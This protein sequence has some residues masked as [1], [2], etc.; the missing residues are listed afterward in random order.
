MSAYKITNKIIE[1]MDKYDIIIAN[2]ANGDMVGHTGKY[3][4]AIKAAKALDNCIKQLYQAVTQRKSIMLIAADHGNC[5]QMIVKQ[6]EKTS[7]T[8]NDVLFSI[9]GL[10][11]K[12]K[13][14][15]LADISPTILE[16]L[17]IKKPREMT[18]TSLLTTNKFINK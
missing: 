18:G 6:G 2:Y 4:A 13:N 12:L 1:V 9:I 11:V 10:D 15:K 5:E 17:K 3:K 16:I 7:H 14:G 8:L